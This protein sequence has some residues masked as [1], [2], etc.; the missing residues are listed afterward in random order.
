SLFRKH[1]SAECAGIRDKIYGLHS[2]ALECY[3]KAVP[4]NFS[5]GI[6]EL[7][8]QVLHHHYLCH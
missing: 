8:R 7:C 2:F 4:I 3:R 1:Q 5:V 6:Y